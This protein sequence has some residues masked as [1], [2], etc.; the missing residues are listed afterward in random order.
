[1]HHNSAFFLDRD[2]IINVTNIINGNPVAIN[3][4]EQLVLVNGIKELIDYM[5]DVGY[6]IICV[7][8]Q[9][10]I[11]R[12]KVSLESVDKINSEIMRLLPK[13]K[14]IYICPHD[15]FENCNCRK[16]KI[17]MI[18]R[19]TEDYYLD[20]NSSFIIGDRPT[21]VQCGRNAGIST[22]FVDYNYGNDNDEI[23]SDY[24]VKFVSE[25]INIF[26]GD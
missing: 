7:T 11:A 26:K 6:I 5:D 2:G 8:N 13:I 12:G 19:A 24:S 4:V 3:N 16:P 15:D 21:D 17:G 14:R 22:I 20:L 18:K 25:I 1:M 23:E 9:P 10:D